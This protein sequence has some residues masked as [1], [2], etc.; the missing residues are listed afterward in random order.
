[1]DKLDRNEKENPM[2]K[3]EAIQRADEAGVQLG[4]LVR[5]LW[6]EDPDQ[7]SRIHLWCNTLRGLKDQW[8]DELDETEGGY[9]QVQNLREAA[10]GASL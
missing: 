8:M 10:C 6:D 3:I 7:A 2:D 1:L 4:N 9:G 5:V